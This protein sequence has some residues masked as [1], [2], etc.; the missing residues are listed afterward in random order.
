MRQYTASAQDFINY[1]PTMTLSDEKW[2]RVQSTGQIEYPAQGT[3]AWVSKTRC[4]GLRKNAHRSRASRLPSLMQ[5][6]EFGVRI[7]SLC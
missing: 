6:A 3:K 2:S 1:C 7:G 4:C 5:E